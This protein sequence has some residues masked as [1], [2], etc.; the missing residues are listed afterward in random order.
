MLDLASKADLQA[1]LRASHDG[2]TTCRM[3]CDELWV[4]RVREKGIPIT[5]L[6]KLL[7]SISGWRDTHLSKLGV[8]TKWPEDWDF[9][10]TITTCSTDV[11]CHCLWL[12]LAGAIRDF[13]VVEAREIEPGVKS[14]LAYEVEGVLRRCREEADHSSMRIAALV[15]RPSCVVR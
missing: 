14:P 9:L 11:Y 12:V 7:N 15:S 10:A 3:I 5:V 2:S 13:G 4:P 6:R 8:P 1:W